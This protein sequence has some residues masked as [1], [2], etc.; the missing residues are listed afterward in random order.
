[1][2]ENKQR[3][4]KEKLKK[5]KSKKRTKIFV[6]RSILNLIQ[7]IIGTA[8]MAAA[9]SFFLLPNQL[10][11]GGFTGVATITYY[12]F[13][14]P[15][16]TMILI[17][18]I[19]LFIMGYIKIG[20]EFFIRSITGTVFL[21]IFI[22]IFDRFEP[23][24][25]DRILACIYGGVLI[26]IG[27]AIILKAKSS[28]G[29]TDLI[30]SI[31]RTYK[32]E[33]RM[34]NLIVIIDIIIVGINVIF[35]RELEIGLYSA[36]TI[37]IMGKM[38]DIVFEGIYFTKLIYIVSDQNE[39]IAKTIGKEIKR[40]T[41]GLFAKG[42]YK[43]DEKIVLLCAAS[44]NDVSRIKQIVNKIDPLAFIII[45]NSREVFGKGFKRE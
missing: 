37:Y 2:K 27:T 30:T 25:E 14:I 19:P 32:P 12:L 28:T 10:S 34:S 39:R 15:V 40:G 38:I 22:D 4:K 8:L 42:M 13:H 6:K 36:I 45:S 44:R 41:T 17:L 23:L 33:I 1:M 3:T 31:A 21:S 26:G 20:R 43:E 16:G 24:T 5:V 29:G 35:F 18:N 7:I 9:V 11:S